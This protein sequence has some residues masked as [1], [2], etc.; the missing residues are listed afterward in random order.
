MSCLCVRKEGWCFPEMAEYLCRLYE[1]SLNDRASD[2]SQLRRDD[3]RVDVYL[4]PRF[5]DADS[6]THKPRVSEI[7][8][9]SALTFRLVTSLAVVCITT[10]T[11]ATDAIE[12]K[13]EAIELQPGLTKG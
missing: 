11:E 13:K 12:P 4:F 2:K 5:L 8:I 3:G 1:N 10:R 7:H 9:Q 6:Y